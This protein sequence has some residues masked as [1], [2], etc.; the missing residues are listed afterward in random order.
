MAS[1]A[2]RSASVFCAAASVSFS[3]EI[4]RSRSDKRL[5][6]L[7]HPGLQLLDAPAEHLGLGGLRHQRAFELHHPV[8]Q[9]LDLAAGFVELGGG[10][11]GVLALAG[12]AVA[13]FVGLA[14]VTADALLQRLDLDAQRGRLDALAVGRRRALAEIGGDLAS[15]A[16]LSESMRSA[17]RSAPIFTEC[18]DSVAC[19]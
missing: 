1:S 17:S 12:Q 14:L 16:C 4:S 13:D 6:L 18:S 9:L 2:R 7:V 11:G 10:R 15:S 19:N 3:R 5:G 8:A